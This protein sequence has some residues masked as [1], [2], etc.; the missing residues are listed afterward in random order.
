[1]KSWRKGF[2]DESVVKDERGA[3]LGE[4]FEGPGMVF[5]GVVAREVG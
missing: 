3:Y 2:R 5:A 4:L 1:M